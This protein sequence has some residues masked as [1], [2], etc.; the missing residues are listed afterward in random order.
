MNHY[1]ISYDITD[2][3]L[4]QKVAYDLEKYGALRLQKSVFIAPNMRNEDIKT[5]KSALKDRMKQH[6][7]H[8]KTDSLLCFPIQKKDIKEMVWAGDEGKLR[9]ILAELLFMLF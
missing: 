5:I 9:E 8:L 7:R 6:P 4:R 3:H 1:I 2:N